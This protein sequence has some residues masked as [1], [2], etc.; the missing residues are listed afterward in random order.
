MGVIMP[1]LPTK[2]SD[3]YHCGKERKLCHVWS[4]GQHA[5][6]QIST[7]YIDD[8]WAS[9]LML[10]AHLLTCRGRC[11]RIPRYGPRDTIYGTWPEKHS[12][13]N[14]PTLH[15]DPELG[16]SWWL[17]KNWGQWRA[18]CW[19]PGLRATIGPLFN[20]LFLASFPLP[21]LSADFLKKS[22]PSRR[23]HLG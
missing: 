8:Q 16:L 14:M 9:R 12:P 4:F 23:P 6:Y 19:V 2:H 17:K 22:F 13:Q 5:Y 18:Y 21:S 1:K 15:V 11:V 20:L 3:M 7:T 10:N